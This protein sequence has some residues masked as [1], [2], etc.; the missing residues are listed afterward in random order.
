MPGIS[1]GAKECRH[2]DG[3]TCKKRRI[4]LNI[5]SIS[6]IRCF[7]C[8]AYEYSEEY[9]KLLKILGSNPKLSAERVK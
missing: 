8:A 1:C 7:D 3:R 9:G 5:K 6:G 4:R 2:N